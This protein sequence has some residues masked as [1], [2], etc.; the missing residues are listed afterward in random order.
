MSLAFFKAHNCIY[1][2]KEAHD[3]NMERKLAQ[4]L[5]GERCCQCKLGDLSSILRTQ[6][7]TDGNNRHCKILFFIYVQ[8]YAYVHTYNKKNIFYE[9]WDRALL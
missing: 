5:N 4:L 3:Q 9:M 2:T 8:W 1:P 7:N 6:M